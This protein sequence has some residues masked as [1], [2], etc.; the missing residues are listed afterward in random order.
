LPNQYVN[1][2]TE[3]DSQGKPLVG[4]NG[5]VL[6]QRTASGHYV[7]DS[8]DG[9]K[10][11]DSDAQKACQAIGGRLPTQQEF[12]DLKTNYRGLPNLIGFR[13]ALGSVYLVGSRRYTNDGCGKGPLRRVKIVRDYSFVIDSGNDINQ[14]PNCAMGVVGGALRGEYLSVRCVAKP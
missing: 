13:Y 9:F 2:I 3:K 10:I 6:C 1:C 14:L 5:L 12:E 8:T 7:G 4:T 11:L